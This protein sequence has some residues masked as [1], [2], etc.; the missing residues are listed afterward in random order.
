MSKDERP[1]A[2]AT[3]SALWHQACTELP[4]S[5]RRLC[6]SDTTGI[7]VMRHVCDFVSFRVFASLLLC[8]VAAQ[9]HFSSVVMRILDWR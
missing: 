7:H 2:L 6:F 3:N 1:A 4:L 5:A 9:I 8:E